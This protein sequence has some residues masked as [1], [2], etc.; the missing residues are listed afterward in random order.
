MGS[1]SNKEVYYLY[2]R[3]A[4]SDDATVVVVPVM[5]V[6]GNPCAQVVQCGDQDQGAVEHDKR[7]L[8]SFGEQKHEK[9][10]T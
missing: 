6:T 2:S 7:R 8:D 9:C 3:K 5:F 10:L 4:Q 1:R